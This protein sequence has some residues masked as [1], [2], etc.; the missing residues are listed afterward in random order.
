MNG[1]EYETVIGLE[2]HAQLLT[3]SKMFCSCAADYQAAPPNTRVCPVCLGMPGVLP[4]I[5]RRAVE[6]TLMTA[7]V[8]N[9]EIPEFSKFDRKN[10][11]Y[12]DLMKGYQISQYD[13]PLSHDGWLEIDLEGET[14]RIGI[15]R[16]HLEED[17]AKLL[18]RS[19]NGG[20]RYSLVDVNRS[21]VPLMEIVG[22]PD[23][24]SPEGARRYLV[25]LRSILQYLGV[26]TGNMEEGSFRCDANVSLRPCGAAQLGAK[27]EV[28][29]M[30]S[31]RS[32]FR[33][34]EYEVE[35]QRHRLERG[36]RIHQETRGWVEETG[37]T[38]S[39]RSK[40]FAHDYRYFPEPDLPP[41]LLSRAWIDEIQSRLPELP[42]VR[43]R[44]FEEEY[45]LAGYDAG[46]LSLARNVADYFEA[47]VR[48]LGAEDG[49]ERQ[50]RAKAVANWILGDLARLLNAGG[51]EIAHCPVPPEALAELVGLVESGR[52]GGPAAK[53]VLAEMYT[54]GRRPEAVVEERG[55]S[56]VSDVAA[57]DGIVAGVLEENA[58]AV[59]D[60][61]G[62]KTQ[63]M[64]FLVGQVMRLSR[65]RAKPEVVREI[66]VRRLG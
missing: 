55:L 21:G 62:G 28:K 34:L 11:P 42:D 32:V 60:Y 12:P 40:E 23:L 29:N 5:N 33:A 8:L 46:Q 10:Y 61:R 56:Q 24:R 41:L 7:L 36:E 39:Q 3:R 2:V 30:N 57:L 50:R 66:L 48:A 65:G 6:F 53:E 9:C 27:V 52:V 15:T 45:G 58:V 4:V 38:V 35:R 54:S 14:Q 31:F 22:E 13:L 20:E 1:H 37:V 25:K 18:H 59:S 64:T 19:G 17:T 43:R 44:R 49:K 51:Q 26:S 63:A 16:V 47:V